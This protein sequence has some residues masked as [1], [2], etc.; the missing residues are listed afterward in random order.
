M[1]VDETFQDGHRYGKTPFGIE[2]GPK[3]D[4]GANLR[5]WV[6]SSPSCQGIL[7]TDPKVRWE[8]GDDAKALLVVP[9]GPVEER[10]TV[11]FEPETG[12]LALMEAMRYKGAMGVKTLWINQT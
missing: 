7:L 5:L 4:Q 12:R 10:F 8:P 9:F 2:E 11:R 3:A 1:K 6:E